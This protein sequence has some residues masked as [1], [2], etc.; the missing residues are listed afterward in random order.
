MDYDYTHHRLLEYYQ[1]SSFYL[2]LIFQVQ[3]YVGTQNKQLNSD[4]YFFLS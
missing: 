1:Y 4:L 3:K 2:F